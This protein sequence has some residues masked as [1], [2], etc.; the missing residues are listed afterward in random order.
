MKNAASSPRGPP[1]YISSHY[2]KPIFYIERNDIYE[3]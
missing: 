3:R 1:Q 2:A